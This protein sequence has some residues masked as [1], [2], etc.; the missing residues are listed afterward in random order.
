[1]FIVLSICLFICFFLSLAICLSVCLCVCLL[2]VCL[3]EFLAICLYVNRSICSLPLYLNFLS[4]C[5]YVCLCVCG[6]SVCLSAFGLYICVCDCLYICSRWGM[7]WW[8]KD[9][10]KT[11]N[12]LNSLTVT[13]RLQTSYLFATSHTAESHAGSKVYTVYE[14]FVDPATPPFPLHLGSH[15]RALLVSP[16]RRHL[17]VTPS[18]RRPVFWGG[19]FPENQ[20]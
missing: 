8:E 5:L 20:K 3:Y 9:S 6:L 2:W 7:R 11:Q 1:M 17:F 12:L 16:D 13:F 18:D 14:T 15:T 4:E 19:L 10:S